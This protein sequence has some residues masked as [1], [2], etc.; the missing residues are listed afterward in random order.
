MSNE[1]AGN[2]GRTFE[3]R[4][5]G[6]QLA[7]VA[8]AP[9]GSA[10]I[11]GGSVSSIRAVLARGRLTEAMLESA[12][13]QVEDLIMPILRSLPASAHFRVSGEEL[14]KVFQL[15]PRGDGAAVST[16]TVESL[17]N[18]LADYSGGSP[19]AWR[20]ASS[21]DGV[22]LGLVVLREVM[23]HGGFRSVTLDTDTRSRQNCPDGVGSTR[24]RCRPMRLLVTLAA[25][26]GSLVAI[27]VTA[28]FVV[29]VLA[30][31]H[32]GLLP[33]ALEVLVLIAGWAVVIGVP[34]WV[35]RMVWRRAAPPM[36]PDGAA[37]ANACGAAGSADCGDHDQGER[38]A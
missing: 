30:G 3:L 4:L 29:L 38:R 17:F 2:Q 26:V 9:G 27:G 24:L 21:P 31:P 22:A 5:E 33:H 8:L 37:Q 35:A 16:E 12:I 34:L 15:M 28:F 14:Q 13:A 25:Y 10:Y 36:P 11:H 6:D 19:V 7:F 23:H 18:E 1:P 32:A 20:H